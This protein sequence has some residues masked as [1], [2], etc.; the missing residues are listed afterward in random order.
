VAV[1]LA[2]NKIDTVGGNVLQSVT[3]RSL[4]LNAAH[5]LS[6]SYDPDR[7]ARNARHCAQGTSCGRE[8]F[9]VQYWGVLLQLQ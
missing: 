9:N 4:K 2:A 5:R 6:A 7:A 8:N 1:D 3:R